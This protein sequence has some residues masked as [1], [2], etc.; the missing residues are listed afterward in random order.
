[1]AMTERIKVEVAYAR[2][3]KQ[4]IVPLE[5]EQGCTAQAAVEASGIAAEFAEID[6]A[7]LKLGIFG[8]AVQADT[9]LRANDRVEIYR[10]LLA[11]PKEVRRRRAEQGK[12]MKKG[13]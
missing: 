12:A 13:A 6:L 4:L 11:D 8:K 3:D 10:P 5:V 1:M 2:P 9:V 7:V